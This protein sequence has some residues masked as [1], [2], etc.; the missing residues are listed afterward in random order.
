MEDPDITPITL[1]A[2]LTPFSSI[3][4]FFEFRTSHNSKINYLYEVSLSDD[5]K[6]FETQLPLMNPYLAFAKPSSC[7]SPIRSIRYLICQTPKKVKEYVQSSKF[8]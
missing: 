2:S 5:T 7:F 1:I 6:I 8:D 3:S 4:S